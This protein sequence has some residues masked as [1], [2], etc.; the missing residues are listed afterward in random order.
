MFVSLLANAKIGLHILGL[1]V[2]LVCFVGV[3]IP[4]CL[5]CYFFIIS[6]KF[7]AVVTQWL[8]SSQHLPAIISRFVPFAAVAAANCINI[9]FMRQR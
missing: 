9:P 6:G 7:I 8:I 2:D 3:S 5:K 1:F 4:F